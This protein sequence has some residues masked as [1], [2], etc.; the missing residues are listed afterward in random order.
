MDR[1]G[2]PKMFVTDFRTNS[3]PLTFEQF[4]I[5]G[6]QIINIPA[7]SDY[8]ANLETFRTIGSDLTE[9]WSKNP[10][11]CRFGYQKS[12]SKSNVPYLLNNNS[13]IQFWFSIF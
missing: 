6:L 12:I 13:I 3:N 1:S 2:E 11:H 4:N 10:I 9:L 7:A 8:T 5:K